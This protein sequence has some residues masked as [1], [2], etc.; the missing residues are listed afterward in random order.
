M[1]REVLTP[2]ASTQPRPPQGT[3]PP[4]Q[5]FTHSRAPAGPATSALPR[6]CLPCFTDAQFKNFF[7]NVQHEAAAGARARPRRRLRPGALP[8]GSELPSA[9]RTGSKARRSSQR[10]DRQDAGAGMRLKEHSRH[11]TLLLLGKRDESFQESHF[12]PF[13]AEVLRQEL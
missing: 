3:S 13:Q 10:G 4:E 8:S 12:S 1:A 11:V 6:A 5:H 2:T 9:P 7:L